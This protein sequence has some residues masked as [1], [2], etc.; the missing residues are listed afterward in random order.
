[1]YFFFLN[2]TLFFKVKWSKKHLIGALCK[3]FEYQTLFSER[4]FF[5]SGKQ[6]NKQTHRKTNPSFIVATIQW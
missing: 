3:R 4:Y 5:G 2:D 1:M 6:T